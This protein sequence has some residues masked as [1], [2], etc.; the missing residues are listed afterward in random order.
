MTPTPA[1]PAGAA[2]IADGP[3]WKNRPF[4][5]LWA[6]Q[7]ISQT[8]QNAIWYGMMVLV[9]HKSG[10]TTQMSVAIMSLIVPSVLFGIIAGAYVDRWD[11]RGVLIATNALRAVIT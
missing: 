4:V 9:Q 11:K 8:A 6:A 2:P 1:Q 3:I 5:L 7:A 10:S